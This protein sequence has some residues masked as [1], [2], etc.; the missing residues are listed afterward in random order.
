MGLTT[1]PFLEIDFDAL[2]IFEPCE[3]LLKLLSV[4]GKTL[5]LPHFPFPTRQ[6]SSEQAHSVEQEHKDF[7]LVLIPI[8]CV[9]SSGIL[10]ITEIISK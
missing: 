5:F 7:K 8:F 4:A 9:S 2:L 10:Q 3:T 1:L 6:P